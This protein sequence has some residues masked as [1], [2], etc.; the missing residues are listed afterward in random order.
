MRRSHPGAVRGMA[1]TV[2]DM[3]ATSTR[4]PARLS[5]SRI[6]DFEQCPKLFHFKSLGLSTPPT[7]ATAKGTL[8]HY[9]LERIFDHPRSQRDVATALGYIEPAWRMMT[10]PFVE[11]NGSE[12]AYETGLR[13][14]EKAWAEFAQPG[15][16]STERRLRDA[17]QYRKLVTPEELPAFIA[18]CEE[19]VRGWFRMETPSKFDPA[20]REFYVAA[21]V[22]GVELHGYIDRLDRVVSADGTA[23]YYVSDYKTGKPPS[24]RFADEA[25]FQLEVYALLVDR[26]LGVHTHQLRLVYVREG[27][28]DAVLTRTVTPGMLKRTTAKITRVA[29]EI[30]QATED[31]VWPTKKQTLCGWC[32]FQNACPAFE[33]GTETLTPREI[34]ERTGAIL[35]EG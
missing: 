26:L 32:V 33:A 5:P 31:G 16:P 7:I 4:S 23:R 21:K 25:F 19:A 12:D 34:A 10:E 20:E 6:K 8:V 11:R 24:Q 28:P 35:Q 27:R 18:A 22:A 17:D 30:S 14:S 9:A 2:P 29:K 13:D 3:A 15:A 1:G